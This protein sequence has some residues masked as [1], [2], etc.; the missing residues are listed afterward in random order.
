MVST[1]FNTRKYF[2]TRAWAIAG[3]IA[4]LACGG[5]D[6]VAQSSAISPGFLEHPAVLSR[7][8]PLRYSRD[9]PL[10]RSL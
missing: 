8:H 4:L 6:A 1:F 10:C 5:C 7:H 9:R 3:S 2:S